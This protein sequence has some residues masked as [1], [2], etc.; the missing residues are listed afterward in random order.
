[1][2][3]TRGVLDESGVRELTE[4]CGDPV[5]TSFYLDV[6]GRHYPR[7][8]DY[9]PHVA[10]LFRVAQKSALDKGEEAAKAVDAGIAR[11]TAWLSG[12]FG[13]QAVRGLAAFSTQGRLQVF[14]L[15]VAVRDQVAVDANPDI[16]QLCEVLASS[17]P[18]LVVAVDAQRSRLLRLDMDRA[19]ELEGPA[20]PVERLAD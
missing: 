15:P 18:V 6:D 17:S 13:R 7:P 4:W 1:M 3:Q 11:I 14:T 8:S 16:A 5:V 19:H 10:A 2:S 12:G 9:A 20:D